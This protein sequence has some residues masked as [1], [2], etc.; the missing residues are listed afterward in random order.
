MVYHKRFVLN[1]DVSNFEFRNRQRHRLVENYEIHQRQVANRLG[2][3]LDVG[4]VQTYRVFA[5]LN[6]F[7]VAIVIKPQLEPPELHNRIEQLHQVQE[8][9][10]LDRESVY[11]LE[12]KVEKQFPMESHVTDVFHL[13]AE[14][15]L[16]NEPR[17]L[18]FRI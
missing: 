13:L 12:Q 15:N 2:A 16:L 7:Q 17:N 14:L 9:V 1:Y 4:I 8:Q 5:E 11:E 10:E 3:V 18:E 6:A